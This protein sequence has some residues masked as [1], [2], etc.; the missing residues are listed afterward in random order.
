[1]LEVTFNCPHCS[2]MFLADCPYEEATIP[3]HL[4]P[5]LGTRCM[6]SQTPLVAYLEIPDHPHHGPLGERHAQE[7]PRY[8][9]R[10]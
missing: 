10:S 8:R 1:M 9:R 6:G 7:W 3:R 5:L 2:R 4:D